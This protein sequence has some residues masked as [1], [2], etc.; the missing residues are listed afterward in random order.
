[1]NIARRFL[2]SVLAGS[3]F[4]SPLAAFAQGD[5][6]VQTEMVSLSLVSVE[7]I[8]VEGVDSFFDIFV[9]LQ[10]PQPPVAQVNDP[11]CDWC[12]FLLDLVMDKLAELADLGAEADKLLGQIDAL[13]MYQDF[14]RD[15]LVDLEA[16]LA[17][18]DSGDFVTNETTGETETAR[19]QAAR[20]AYRHDTYAQWQAGKISSDEKMKRDS[21]SYEMTEAEL[22]T[23]YKKAKKDKQNEIQKL[24]GEIDD[25]QDDIDDLNDDLGDIFDEMEKCDRELADLLDALEDC[26]DMCVF[27]P[28]N[29]KDDLFLPDDV[30]G[31]PPPPPPVSGGLF[32]GIKDWLFGPPEIPL[33]PP[34][35]PFGLPPLGPQDVL[36]PIPVPEVKCPLCD[37]LRDAIIAKKKAATALE[38]KIKNMEKDLKQ[39]DSDL[40]QAER[41]LEAAQS[42]WDRMHSDDFVRNENT[43]ET[44][45]ART[46]AGRKEFRRNN[47]DYSRSSSDLTGAELEKWIQKAEARLQAELAAAKKKVNESR[48]KQK[49]IQDAIQKARDELTKCKKEIQ[50]MIDALAECEKLC[51]DL[52]A[53]N[54]VLGGIPLPDPLGPPLVLPDPSEYEYVLPDETAIEVDTDTEAGLFCDWFGLFCADDA[55]FDEDEDDMEDELVDLTFDDF[56][57]CAQT[58]NPNRCLPLDHNENGMFD[59]SDLS[60][61]AFSLQGPNGLVFPLEINAMDGNDQFTVDDL[62]PARDC[63]IDIQACEPL[64]IGAPRDNFFAGLPQED[65]LNLKGNDFALHAVNGNDIILGPPGNDLINIGG[66][67]NDFISG[68]PSTLPGDLFGPG[69]DSILGGPPSLDIIGQGIPT[70]SEPSI[71]NDAQ[72]GQVVAAAVAAY[73]RQNPL[74][75]CEKLVVTVRRVRVGNRVSYT[76]KIQRVNDPSVCPPPLDPPQDFDR[77]NVIHNPVIDDVPLCQKENGYDSIESCRGVCPDPTSCAYDGGSCFVCTMHDE[78]EPQPECPDVAHTSLDT[79][80]R[81][82][83]NGTCGEMG[84]YKGCYVCRP[85]DLIEE[86]DDESELPPPKLECDSPTMEE[87]ACRNSCDGTCVK[88]YTRRDSVKCFTCLEAEEEDQ[89]DGPSCPSGTAPDKASCESACGSQGGVCIDDNEDGCFECLVVNCPSGTFKDECPSNCSD[90]CDVVGSQHGVSCY[91]CKQS[92][93]DVCSSNGYG[94]PNTDHSSAILSEL[95]GYSC[96]SGANIS[97]QTATINGCSCIGDYSLNVN[98]TPPVCQGTPCGDVTCGESATCQDDDTTVTV[99]CNWGGWEQLDK[100]QFRPVVGN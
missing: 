42:A 83:S 13:S 97:I 29:P 65:P 43:G 20:R 25:V 26:W 63:L 90:G 92:C 74:G 94:G 89:D 55:V 96:V 49:G 15:E 14:L 60:D 23:W 52:D 48:T 24:K 10:V 81:S 91:Q 56:V 67:S 36:G 9:D 53:L 3:F 71:Q 38:T 11:D 40:A 66:G 37:P 79:C 61:Y 8:N 58:F 75:P 17:R 30:F 33:L 84:D 6:T 16:E 68:G 85:N 32:G 31:P 27:G 73:L 69:D 12:D 93:E 50:E 82:C 28:V 35:P 86:D 77:T 18:M 4:I 34:F 5:D 62:G 51:K 98:N 47:T 22:D 59:D 39:A 95:N 87:S 19:N 64:G 88:S 99:N 2:V 21:H 72:V 46:Q 100:H 41:E 76:V 80:K 70:T 78:P 57:E 54:G 7:P 1:M 45:T 44:E